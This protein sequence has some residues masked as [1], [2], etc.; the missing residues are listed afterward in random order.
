MA[1]KSILE[2]VEGLPADVAKE[3]KRDEATGKYVLDVDGIDNHP[4]VG[5]LRNALNNAK[6]ERQQAKEAAAAATTQLE[7]LNN[8]LDDMRRGAIPK[9]DVEALEASWRT[10]LEKLTNDATERT[11]KLTSQLDKALRQST[12]TQ[13]A[14]DLF[15][16]P[17]LGLP[18]V[19]PRLTMVEEN[20]EMAVRVVGTDGKPSAATLDDFKAELLQSK[21]LAPILKGTQAHGGGAGGGQGG[22]GAPQKIDLLN[23]SPK[24]LVAHLANKQGS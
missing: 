6:T 24:E 3:Y 17:V 13:L 8:Q 23:A 12:A 10:K 5:S 4:G 2:S 15:V 20:G 9:G 22:G 19:L 21:D 1:L 16:N 18:H 11:G 14:A 7:Q